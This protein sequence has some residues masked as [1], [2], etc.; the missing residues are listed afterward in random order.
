MRRFDLND[1]R[2]LAARHGFEVTH[3]EIVG[4][5]TMLEAWKGDVSLVCTQAGKAKI[6]V[7]AYKTLADADYANYR[8][9]SS[10]AA[11]LRDRLDTRAGN[12]SVHML[13]EPGRS[14][15]SDEEA[16][17]LLSGPGKRIG[18]SVA[19]GFDSVRNDMDEI[20][21]VVQELGNTCIVAVE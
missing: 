17:M 4:S 11:A 18:M 12:G 20:D 13:K 2:Q 3:D 19:C 14:K 8:R 21:G 9:V 5:V 10:L 6:T 15:L 16:V 7:M 1:V